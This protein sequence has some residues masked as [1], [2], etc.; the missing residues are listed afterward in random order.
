M[1]GEVLTRAPGPALRPFVQ[2]F[3]ASAEAPGGGA[4]ALRERVLPSGSMHLVVRL[5]DDPLRLF[6]GADDSVGRA[7]GH[8]IVGGARAASYVR[9][10]SRPVRSVGAQLHPCAAGL[11]LGV[12]AGEL[13]G[14]HT[15]LA[16]LWGARATWLRERLSEAPTLAARIDLFERLLEDRIQA[17]SDRRREPGQAVAAHA[18][19]RFHEGAAVGAVVLE[20]GYSHR[21]FIELFQREVGL[22]PKLYCRVQRLQQA[23]TLAGAGQPWGRAAV[24]A[25]YADQAHLTRE[26]RELGGLT[27]GEHRAAGGAHA[28][29]VPLAA[30]PRQAG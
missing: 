4:R 7:V 11:L 8:A 12:P 25:G 21:R 27:P 13:A 6:D 30:R 9:D 2:R 29:H 10:V 20:S 26:L 1:S 23:L 16:D 15:D 19:A 28:L 3:W 14:R 24:S 5:S 22:A 17:I 18:V